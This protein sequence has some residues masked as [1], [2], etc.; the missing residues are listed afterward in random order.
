MSVKPLSDE[1]LPGAKLDVIK[2]PGHWLLARLGKRVLRPG[3]LELTRLLLAALNIGPTDR[4]VEFA[5]G[6][7]ATAKL[8]LMRNPASYTGIERDGAAAARIR[9]YLHGATQRCLVGQ[10]EATGLEDGRA[11]VVYGEAMLTMQTDFQK[12]RIIAEAYRILERDGRYGIHELALVGDDLTSELKAQIQK[13]LA[14]VAHVGARPLTADEWR[15]HLTAAGF[16]VLVVRFAPM[17][18]LEPVRFVRD[19]GLAVSLRF[20]F[21]LAR[22]RDARRRVLAMRRVFRQYRNNLSAIMLMAVK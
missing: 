10:A 9:N 3:G 2:M 19:E 6:V 21:R 18:L 13:D 12:R 7:G 11:T 8:A 20:V 22:D 17:R 4:V 16:T 1:T 14:L 15:E 5:P